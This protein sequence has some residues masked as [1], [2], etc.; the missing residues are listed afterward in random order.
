MDDSERRREQQWIEDRRTHPE[1]VGRGFSRATPAWR[2]P[3]RQISGCLGPVG[4]WGV[5]FL[6]LVLLFF[7]AIYLLRQL[8]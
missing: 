6:L 3:G 8:L 1:D 7:S 2:T 4:G 5:L